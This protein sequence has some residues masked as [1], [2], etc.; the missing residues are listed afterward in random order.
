MVANGLT[1]CTIRQRSPLLNKY[2]LEFKS[3]EKWTFQIRLFSVFCKALS[4]SGAEIR[5]RLFRHDTW[6]LLFPPGLDSLHLVAALAFIHRE[7]QRFA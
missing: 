5:V 2:M 4:A 6:Y 7:R 3:G 1:V